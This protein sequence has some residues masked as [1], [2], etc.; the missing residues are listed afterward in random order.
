MHLTP[1]RSISLC[2]GMA[3]FILAC[4][5]KMHI[6]NWDQI[7]ESDQRRVA[8]MIA[9]DTTALSKC[10]A[11][12]LR[13]VHTNGA[14]ENKQEFLEAIANG[15]YKFSQY[16]LDSMQYHL[17]NGLVAVQGSAHIKVFAYQKQ[18]N[19]KTRYTALYKPHPVYGWQL[20]S[21][22]N[23]KLVDVVE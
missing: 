21:W 15:K 10:L 9:V 20:S 7:G 16:K 12:D 2:L 11:P 19:F 23:T 13:W 17:A 22:Q 18:L 14:M 8:A 4:S 3:V 6:A 1:I 5:R